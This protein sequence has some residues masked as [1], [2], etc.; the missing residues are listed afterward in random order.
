M[1]PQEG[2]ETEPEVVS[3]PL[4]NTIRRPPNAMNRSGRDTATDYSRNGDTTLED[5]DAKSLQFR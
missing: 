5:D 2:E 1:A 3:P 4:T